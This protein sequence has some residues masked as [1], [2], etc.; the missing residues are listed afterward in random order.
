M[1]IYSRIPFRLLLAAVFLFL[2]AG[3]SFAAAERGKGIAKSILPRELKNITISKDFL[4]SKEKEAAVIQAMEGTVVVERPEAKQAYFAA[5]GDKL[6]AKDVIYT[7]K[8]SRCKFQLIT[9]D[10]VSQGENTRISIK[11]FLDD[12]ENS[13]KSSLFGM[14]RGMAIFTTVHTSRYFRR[15][16]QVE[17][18]T[19]VSGVRGSKFGLQ[20][21]AAT[22]KSTAALPLLLADNSANSFI[23]LAAIE[24]TDTVTVVHG[25]EGKVEIKSTKDN[26]IQFLNPGESIEATFKGLGKVFETPAKAIEQ[27]MGSVEIKLDKV[28]KDLDKKGKVVEKKME[29]QINVINRFGKSIEDLEKKLGTKKEE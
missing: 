29:K 23:Y 10:T 19:A 12:R 26:N 2:L 11:E 4:D 24:K 25:M 20:V 21:K 7:L 27:F 13:S 3:N 22:G 14:I 8:K 28:G 9:E 17:T 18:P 15:S 1:N 5:K 6:F 16:L